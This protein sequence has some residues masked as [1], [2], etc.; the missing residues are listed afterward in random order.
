MLSADCIYLVR[1]ES[2]LILENRRR[3]KASKSS[4]IFRFGK[5]LRLHCWR[6]Q[7]ES[8]NNFWSVNNCKLLF[9][10]VFS[11]RPKQIKSSDQMLG[12]NWL[13]DFER[14]TTKRK[15]PTEELKGIQKVRNILKVQYIH[16][17]IISYQ[18]IFS[19]T[20]CVSTS[21]LLSGYV[22]QPRL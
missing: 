2:L 5:A 4:M 17:A 6:P 3:Q 19:S 21:Q 8:V 12:V 22:R 18:P 15:L 16:F 13:P 10:S 7:S 14:I 1:V 9:L 20:N 11:F